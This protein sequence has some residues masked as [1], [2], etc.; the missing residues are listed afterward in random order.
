MKNRR[1]VNIV[2]QL[3]YKTREGKRNSI[4]E[5]TKREI[6]RSADPGEMIEREN[7]VGQKR[8]DVFARWDG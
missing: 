8:G 2:Q 3:L 6:K 7:G 5:R 1:T 4:E